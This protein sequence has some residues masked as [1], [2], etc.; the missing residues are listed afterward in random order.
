MNFVQPIRDKAKLEQMYEILQ[1]HNERDFILFLMGVSTGLRISDLL[2]LKKE[3]IYEQ[4]VSIR[5]KKTKKPKQ[6][7]IPPYIKEYLVP[8]ARSLKDGDYLFKSRN[9]RNRPI[10]RSRAYRILNA[11]AKKARIQRIGTHTMRKTFGYHYYMETSDIATLQMLFNHSSQE[12][13]LRYIGITQDRLDKAMSKVRMID[14]K[15]KHHKK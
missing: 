15:R 5:E 3:I 9:G 4:Y 2:R 13:T 14:G 1:E 6:F 11:A 7:K 10:D 8:Y 12:I